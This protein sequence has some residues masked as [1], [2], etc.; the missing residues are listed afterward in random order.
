M[1]LRR[2]NAQVLVLWFCLA[3]TVSAIAMTFLT[4]DLMLDSL[5]ISVS[6]LTLIG[7]IFSGSLLLTERIIKTCN[8]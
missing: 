7:V 6:V 2:F 1:H 4:K 5:A 3:A 8:S